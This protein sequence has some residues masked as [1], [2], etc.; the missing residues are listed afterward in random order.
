MTRAAALV[1]VVGALTIAAPPTSV[2]DDSPI[3]ASRQATRTLRFEGVVRVEW[4]DG[5]GRH[6]ERVKV[7]SWNGTMA[8]EGATD[9]AASDR[10]RFVYHRG[11]GWAMVWPAELAFEDRPSP[12]AKYRVI[13]MGRGPTVA[14]RPTNLVEVRRGS[15]LCDLVYTDATTGLVLRREQYD[16]TGEL[17][18]TV[19]FETLDTNTTTPVSVPSRVADRS[20]DTVP[21][22]SPSAPYRAPAALGAGYELIGA[23]R[24]SG[25]L[26][27]LYSD[28]IYDLSVFEQRGRLDRDDRPAGRRHV[29]LAGRD[30][31]QVS[32]PGGEVVVW[33]AGGAVF[34][35]VGE[36]PIDD[37]LAAATTMPSAGQPSLVEKLRRMCGSLLDVFSPA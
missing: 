7:R 24:Q 32:W 33:Q 18:R 28:G 19:T 8:V 15:V 14:D 12:D 23:Y 13:A 29:T 5:A 10:A 11:L 17:R 16:S 37:V 22:M 3:D 9:L 6:V 26:H 4:V 30:A 21:G 1:A 2:A 27:L 35:A 20:P 36:A 34:T 25:T 31:W